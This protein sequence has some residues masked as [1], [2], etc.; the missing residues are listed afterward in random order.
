MKRS[1]NLLSISRHYVP[2]QILLQIYYG[3]FHSHLSYGSQIWT[4]KND[5]K[6]TTALQ[7]R[8][9]RLISW[10]NFQA[11]S[12][13]LF[14]E[15]K[16]LKLRDLTKM[17][18]LFV[19]DVLNARAP[20]YFSDYFQLNTKQHSHDTI[21]NP[22]STH[23]IPIGSLKLP[24]V[25]NEQGKKTI[26]YSLANTWNEFVKDIA[27]SAT[28]SH[29]ATSL[30][31]MSRYSFKHLIKNYLFTWHMCCRPKEKYSYYNF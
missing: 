9:V 31:S 29:V 25:K 12:T 20:V 24:N 3:Q 17:N 26:K 4:A 15:L 16:V 23:S 27:R 13:P 21:N 18:N 14:K 2:K 11:P 7:K 10:S 30:K 28:Y 22:L 6:T 8:A 1:N 5:L 19:H